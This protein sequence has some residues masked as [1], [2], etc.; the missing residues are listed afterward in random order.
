MNKIELTS[1][2][3][4]IANKLITIENPLSVPVEFKKDQLVADTDSVSFNP[5]QFI[6]PPKSEFGIEIVYRPLIA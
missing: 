3:R 2:V 4:E 1:I 5:P 6:I